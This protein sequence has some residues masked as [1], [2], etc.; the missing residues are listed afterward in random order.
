MST[1]HTFAEPL[2]AIVNFKKGYYMS[3]EDNIFLLPCPFCGG[4]PTLQGSVRKW[5][6][7]ADCGAETRRAEDYPSAVEWWNRRPDTKVENLQQQPT[8]KG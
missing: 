2:Y 6:G 8:N 4:L 1:R 3:A 5:I 7:C